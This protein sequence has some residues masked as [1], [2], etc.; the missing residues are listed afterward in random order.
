MTAACIVIWSVDT[1]SLYME[2]I[3]Q[4]AQKHVGRAIL[5]ARHAQCGII[6]H[7][8]LVILVNISTIMHAYTA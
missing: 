8:H 6:S 1:A 7:V 2:L 4:L 5:I 3:T